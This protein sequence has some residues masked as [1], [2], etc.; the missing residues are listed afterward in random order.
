MLIELKPDEHSKQKSFNGKALID[1]NSNTLLSYLTPIMRKVGEN[2]YIRL[3]NDACL[4]N[5]T[6]KHIKAFSGLSKA[7]FIKLPHM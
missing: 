1:T 2:R 3:C 7:E 6:L 4:T 5:T